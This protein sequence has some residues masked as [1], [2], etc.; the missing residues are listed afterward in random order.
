MYLTIAYF[1]NLASTGWVDQTWLQVFLG[2]G[3]SCISG[4]LI[5]IAVLFILAYTPAKIHNKQ[6]DDKK[7][8]QT[9]LEDLVGFREYDDIELIHYPYPNTEKWNE[10]NNWDKSDDT[11]ALQINN[12]QMKFIGCNIKLLKAE[13][14]LIEDDSLVKNGC[15]RSWED[16][17]DLEQKL[18]RWDN[19]QRGKN[20]LID[21]GKESEEIIVLAKMF[22]NDLLQS[23]FRFSYSDKIS[24]VKRFGAE[25]LDYKAKVSRYI[26]GLPL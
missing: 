14:K 26:P 20:G 2:L 11:L 10:K 17:P 15:S 8:L 19:E 23:Y 5:T 6:D 3:S 4:G 18:F 25:Y 7:E 24:D 9:K 13:Y 22:R 21:I 1:F 16:V 12:G